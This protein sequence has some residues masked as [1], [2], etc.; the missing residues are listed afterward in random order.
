MIKEY[1]NYAESA[2]RW[3]QQIPSHWELIRFKYLFEIKKRIAGKLGFD[4]LSITQKGIKVKNIE[5]GEGQVASD[6]SKYQLVEVGDF[7]MNHMDLLTGY[8]DRSRYRGVTSPDYRVFSLTNMSCLPEFALYVLQMGYNDH[9]FYPLGQGAAHVGRWRLPTESFKNFKAP[10]PP[11]EEQQKIV[12][13][14]DN[15]LG[16]IDEI[17]REKEALIELLKEKR[18]ALVEEAIH[19]NPT[20]KI[21]WKWCTDKIYREISPQMDDNYQAVGLYNR[22][23]GIFRKPEALGSEL[24]DSNFHTIKAGDLILSGQFAWEGSVSIVTREFDGLICSHRYHV[25]TGIIDIADTDF[26]WAFLTTQDGDFLLNQ[27]SR[28][29]AGRNRPL[30]VNLLENYEINLPCIELQKEISKFVKKE[31]KIREE[32]EGFTKQLKIRRSAIIKAA[33]TGKID[34]REEV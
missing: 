4:V 17:I 22:G 14:L 32:L 3:I 23:R 18:Q 24:G 11:L 6:Y 29:A 28:G 15:E 21:R 12:T 8:V 20:T 7:A 10:L 16:R 9:V 30:N 2:E 26:L 33:V 34:I 27:C 13:F 1:A 25:Y 19:S 5:S 31:R